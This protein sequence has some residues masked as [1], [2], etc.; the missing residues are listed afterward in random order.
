MEVDEHELS[1]ADVPMREVGEDRKPLNTSITRKTLPHDIGDMEN[2]WA[3]KYTVNFGDQLD[4][5]PNQVLLRIELEATCL[6]RGSFMSTEDLQVEGKK[7]PS[8]TFTLLPS[9]AFRAVG[10]PVLDWLAPALKQQRLRGTLILVVERV[11]DATLPALV[12]EL[13]T[14]C[15]AS[16]EPPRGGDSKPYF[17]LGLNLSV[18]AVAPSSKPPQQRL[19]QR[20]GSEDFE[21]WTMVA[22]PVNVA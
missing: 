16:A 19:R 6:V 1:I 21:E 20:T 7:V 3:L 4:L 11:L 22:T 9:S 2:W 12:F 8:W 18:R 13:R 10:V 14:F 17:R 5:M 15:T